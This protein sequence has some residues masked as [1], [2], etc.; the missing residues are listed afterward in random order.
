MATYEKIASTTL[1]SNATTITFS[2]IPQTYTDLILKFNIRTDIAGGGAYNVSIRINGNSGT[3]YQTLR[4]YGNASSVLSFNASGQSQT[5]AGMATAAG[6]TAN[7][8][9]SNE[10]YLPNYKWS[11]AKCGSTVSVHENNATAAERF[12]AANYINLTDPITSI[13]LQITGVSYNFV[14]YSSAYLY[15]ISNA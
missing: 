14:P 8:F 1:S 12:F 6:D 15:G 3:N 2:S 4:L 5:L 9:S 7:T 13:E 11:N 10:I